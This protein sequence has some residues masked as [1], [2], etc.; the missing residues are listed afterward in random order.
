[1]LFAGNS[2]HPDYEFRKNGF[3]ALKVPLVLHTDPDENLPR[4]HAP[5]AFWK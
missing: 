4:D 5:Q 1:M 2:F 3:Q